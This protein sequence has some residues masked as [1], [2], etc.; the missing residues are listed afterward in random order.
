MTTKSGTAKGF[1]PLSRIV[2]PITILHR[3]YI[4]GAPTLEKEI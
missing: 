3:G 1:D 2:Y 4:V